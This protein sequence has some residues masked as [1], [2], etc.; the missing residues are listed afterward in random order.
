MYGEMRFNMGMTEQ[1]IE[2]E[3][4]LK[5]YLQSQDILFFQP[6]G[7]GLNKDTYTLYEVKMKSEPFKPPPFY[8]HGLEIYQIKA[9]LEF[10]RKTGMR[11]RF[12]VF[13]SKDNVVCSA[14]LDELEKG[15][16]FDTK[17]GI[18]IYPVDNFEIEN[19]I[20]NPT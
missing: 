5:R 13:Q 17:N 2:G 7:I 11:C 20:D 9:R 18:R 8:G 16:H 6:D 15:E 4:K 12:I 14:W 19:F 1:G 3:Q 10:Y